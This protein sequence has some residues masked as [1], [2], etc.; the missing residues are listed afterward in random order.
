MRG[1]RLL[2]ALV[3]M[4]LLAIIAF[5]SVPRGVPGAPGQ[6]QQ[7]AP[8][9]SEGCGNLTVYVLNVSQADSIFIITPANKTILIDA[10]SKMKAN[11][12]SNVLAFLNR[13]NVTRIDYVVATHYHE[14]HIGGMDDIL[15]RFETGRIYENG[16]CGNLSSETAKRFHAYALLK[17][18]TVVRT[19][20]DLPP[21]G[22]LSEAKLIF[23]YGMPGGC[24]MGNE[25]DNSVLLHIAYGNTSF[26]FTGDCDE[27]CESAVMA[28]GASLK[29]DFLKAGHHGSSTSSSIPFLDAVGARYFAI[30]ADKD[31]SVKDGY[32][33]PRE[34][35]LEK[36][37]ARSTGG[38][39]RTDLNGNVKAVSDGNRLSVV[40]D[41]EQGEC[42]IFSGYLSADAASYSPIPA[43]S[44]RCG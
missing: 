8:V 41:A 44:G 23:P 1:R 9:A 43:L 10:G 25:N 3:A 18:S 14:D 21:D 12:S 6:P 13:M 7:E 24:S 31:R 39:F 26:L 15:A 4:L 32:F 38:T 27:N 29:S 36:L 35:M 33:H 5:V 34:T 11:S 37:Y 20:E 42:G 2:F 28:Q 40:P 17:G 22:C 30:S 16:N 19:T